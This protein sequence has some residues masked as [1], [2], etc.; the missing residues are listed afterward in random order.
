MSSKSYVVDLKNVRREDWVRVGGKASSLGELK[1]LGFP[2]PEGFVVTTEAYDYFLSYNGLEECIESSLAKINPDDPAS[3]EE[4]SKE[5]REAMSRSRLPAELAED[6]R[7]AYDALPVK[8]V[9]VRSS[10][11]VEDS[12]QESFA[13]QLETFLN[14]KGFENVERLIVQCYSSLW[15]SRAIAYRERNRISHRN[16]KM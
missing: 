15:G 13:G 1:H 2:V 7:R 9:A 4:C 16:L 3:I 12:P 14:V 5:I 10:A 11:T 8:S 6:L